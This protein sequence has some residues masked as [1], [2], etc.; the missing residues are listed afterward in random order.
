[1]TSRDEKAAIIRALM[2][3]ARTI[4]GIRLMIVGMKTQNDSDFDKGSDQT[5]T[6]LD[7]LTQ[8]IDLLVEALTKDG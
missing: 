4:I 1:V 5:F 3:L 8:Q 6:A 2:A 7:A